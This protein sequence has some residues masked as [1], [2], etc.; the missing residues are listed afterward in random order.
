MTAT[1]KK[2]LIIG[3]SWVGDMVMAQSLFIALTQRHSECLIDVLAPEW[4]LPILERMPEVRRGIVMPVGHG[5]FAL[6]ERFTLGK[7][8]RSEAYSQAIVLPNSLKS[9]LV[10]MFANIPIRTGWRGE[11]RYGL[12]NDIRLLVKRHYPLM[13]QRFVALAYDNELPY[14]SDLLKWEQ[15]PRPKLQINVGNTETL[16]QRFG[17]DIGKPVLA[18]CPGA[19]FGPAKRWPEQ[20]YADVAKHYLEKGWQ[21]ALF[22][23]ANDQAVAQAILSSLSLVQRNHCISLAGQ[24]Q[25]S[26]AVD[27]LAQAA[28]VVS[29]DSGLMHIAAALGRPMVVVYGSTSA[30]FTPPLSDNVKIE[31]IDVDCGP[32]FKRECPLSE[33]QN[34]LKCL[35]GLRPERI[36]AALDQI[37]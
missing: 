34:P 9:A 10:P 2:I 20:H 31:Q 28:G 16:Y 36:I 3:P 22:G 11:M 27:L 24:T 29:N 33:K 21:V 6:N 1:A 25:L 4:S 13:V 12:L 17:L 35:T 5:K 32:C 37:I 7:S 14:D 26:E 15:L 8:L 30:D 19:E 18:L 23:S